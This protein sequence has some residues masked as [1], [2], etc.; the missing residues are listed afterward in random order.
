MKILFLIVTLAFCA[1]LFS[2]FLKDSKMPILA[3]LVPLAAGLIILLQLIPLVISVFREVRGMTRG[4]DLSL[5]YVPLL[6]KV[7][8]VAYVGEFAGEL[9]RDAGENGLAKKVELA[10]KVIIMLMALPLLKAILKAALSLLK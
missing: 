2:V 6:L 8:A 7:V 4:V 5:D 1:V 10:V 9:C 3:L